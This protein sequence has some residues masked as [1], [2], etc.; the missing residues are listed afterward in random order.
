[1]YNEAIAHGYTYGIIELNNFYTTLV[2][3]RNFLFWHI[4]VLD[5]KYELI[6]QNKNKKGYFDEYSNIRCLVNASTEKYLFINE[7][8]DTRDIRMITDDEFLEI[9]FDF[10]I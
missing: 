8:F 9:I 10:K 6:E 3:C 7:K 1:M 4:K 2:K 5:G